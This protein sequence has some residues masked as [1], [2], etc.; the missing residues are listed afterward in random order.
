MLGVVGSAVCYQGSAPELSSSWR[1]GSLEASQSVHLS[2]LTRSLVH[3]V[4]HRKR[5]FSIGVTPTGA[6]CCKKRWISGIR[7]R[8]RR[9]SRK[10]TGSWGVYEPAHDHDRTRHNRHRDDRRPRPR[11]SRIPTTG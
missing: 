4:Q 9:T 10:K 3:P 7:L 6:S 8:H 1:A 11:N 2:A 5:R